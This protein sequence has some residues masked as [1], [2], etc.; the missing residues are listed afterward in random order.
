[1]PYD[2]TLKHPPSLISYNIAHC[3]DNGSANSTLPLLRFMEKEPSAP[4]P[5]ENEPRPSTSYSPRQRGN[6]RINHNYNQRRQDFPNRRNELPTRRGYR[7][8]T[9]YDRKWRS[10]NRNHNKREKNVEMS[11]NAKEFVPRGAPSLENAANSF[12]E[13]HLNSESQSRFRVDRGNWNRKSDPKRT[14]VFES[15]NSASSGRFNSRGSWFNKRKMG[16][17]SSGG[18]RGSDNFAAFWKESFEAKKSGEKE[19]KI[20]QRGKNFTFWYNLIEQL[21]HNSCEC[22]VCCDRVRSQEAV[23]SCGYCYNIFHLKC[24]R[25][26]A[27]SSA[28]VVEDC[29]WRC[30]VCQHI[31]DMIPSQYFCFC[32]K[33]RDPPWNHYDTPHSC[34]E[35]CNKAL[36]GE[37]CVHK[38][39]IQ[40]HPGPC[41][42]CQM[43]VER[44]CACGKTIKVVRC[45]ISETM[46]CDKICGRLL[47]CEMHKCQKQCHLG[48]CNECPETINQKCHCGKQGKEVT[49]T[50][51]TAARRFSCGG[52]CGQTL[53]CGR[54]TC[55]RICHGGICYECQLSPEIVTHC[56]CGKTRLSEL[57]AEV[58]VLCTDP[59]P[60]C[61]QV[62]EKQLKCG[63]EGFDEQFCHCGASIRYPPIP[64]GTR[65]PECQKPCARN[66][67]CAHP[68]AHNC[69]SEQTCPPCTYLTEKLCSGEHEI[70]SNVPCYLTVVSCG[71]PCNKPLPCGIHNCPL[72][73]HCGTCLKPGNKCSLPCTK[74]RAACNHP[75]AQPCHGQRP[76]PQSFC[77]AK[78]LVTCECGHLSETISCA[79]NQRTIKQAAAATMATKLCGLQQGESVDISELVKRNGKNRRL[80]CNEQCALIERN[81]RLAL[82]LQIRN[83]EL[84]NKL[85]PPSYT[86]F[87]KD[88]TKLN[89]RFITNAYTKFT[90]VVQNAKQSKQKSRSYAFPPMNREQR[91]VIHELGEYFG[92][93]TQSYDEEPKKNVVATALRDKSW[94]PSVSIMAVVERESV[95]Q[96][97]PPPIPHRVQNNS[98]TDVTNT[99]VT[100]TTTTAGETKPPI[101]YF[102]YNP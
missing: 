45:G 23:W 25:K 87:L 68:V 38:C 72:T 64:C 58:R 39:R 82:A 74:L 30:P 95:R 48:P 15:R 21:A 90:E 34:G 79:E 44:S 16:S 43:Q 73:C 61:G 27:E 62:C 35:P 18:S 92:C 94:L 99:N 32:G 2:K 78:V 89:L 52:L 29:G 76:C 100:P 55:E 3:G 19:V 63:S 102:D 33:R 14:M 17:G 8:A 59:I 86:E 9:G 77:K 37:G 67:S 97:A 53:N 60:S 10:D 11:V 66:H 13:L 41:P 85:G 20:S 70:R 80:E 42:Q 49:C 101:N 40:C 88:F 83:P 56:H 36:V 81:R 1:A 24:I 96:R 51:E 84:T 6:P 93:S 4:I 5:T 57:S 46:L 22:T 71:H 47:N 26:W 65:P 7:G 69:H 54:H 91:R 98:K 31:S 12:D 50:L 28:A 75:C